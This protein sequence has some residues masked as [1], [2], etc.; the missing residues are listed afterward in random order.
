M[1]DSIPASG[2]MPDSAG[3]MTA[4]RFPA[5]AAATAIAAVTIVLPMPVSVPEMRWTVIAPPRADGPGQAVAG[6]RRHPVRCGRATAG[7]GSRGALGDHVEGGLE[8]GPG[9][10]GVDGQPEPGTTVRSGRW[11]EAAD[12]DT[13]VPA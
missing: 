4:T 3:L 8:V 13:A 1:S 7:A 5:R 6:G 11:T 2:T 12:R 9:Y 10:A